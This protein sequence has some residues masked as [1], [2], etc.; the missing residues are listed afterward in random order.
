MR[1]W[2]VYPKIIRPLRQLSII[3]ELNPPFAN[4]SCDGEDVGKRTDGCGDEGDSGRC[5]P[6]I[7]AELKLAQFSSEQCQGDLLR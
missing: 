4:Q 5:H 2:D 1:V 3:R 6:P 7:S